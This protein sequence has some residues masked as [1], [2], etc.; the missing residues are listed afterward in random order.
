MRRYV[1]YNKNGFIDGSTRMYEK[2]EGEMSAP[3]AWAIFIL[4]IVVM[5]KISGLDITNIANIFN[6]FTNYLK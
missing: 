4:G 5:F 3:L 2:G 1:H 6:T